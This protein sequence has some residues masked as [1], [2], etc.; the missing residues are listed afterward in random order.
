MLVMFIMVILSST[1]VQL[2]KQMETG[3]SH[4]SN[5]TSRHQAKLIADG[6]IQWASVLLMQDLK[7]NSIDT[8]QDNWAADKLSLPA[9][10]G[11]LTLRIED[12]QG[13][14][15]INNLAVKAQQ[16]PQKK[17]FKQLLS[18]AGLPQTS[19]QAI[20]NWIGNKKTAQKITTDDA[21]YLA[22]EKPYLSAQ[23]MITG[24]AELSLI[25][26]FEDQNLTPLHTH[27]TSL[28]ELTK[29][30]I[31]TASTSVVQAILNL[32]PDKAK[33]LTES[34]KQKGITSL[35][36]LSARI[37]RPITI[38]Q[39]QLL[40]VTSSYFIAHIMV[41]YQ[42]IQYQV[43]VHFKRGKKQINVYNRV[44]IVQ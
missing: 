8:L 37:K 33:A 34:L 25:K 44:E 19:S 36:Q 21:Y 14:Y 6:A 39:R 38:K 26:G 18:Q 15:N 40:S 9:V 17:I 28:P 13:R 5:L 30:N 24:T 29:I 3:V 41:N 20:I 23:Q 27:I 16:Q 2:M 31:N 1:M 10:R 22:K 12:A 35:S 42:S 32:S 7:D 11:E 43:R 4:H